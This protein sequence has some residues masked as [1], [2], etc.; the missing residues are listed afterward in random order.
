[1]LACFPEMSGRQKQDQLAILLH[2]NFSFLFLTIT[3]VREK[4]KKNFNR[5]YPE[6]TSEPRLARAVEIRHQIYAHCVIL[7]RRGPA[8]VPVGLAVDAGV[9]VLAVAVV[10]RGAGK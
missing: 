2:F 9:A 6:L 4:L 3:F 10:T 1:M 7:A 8:L 5:S